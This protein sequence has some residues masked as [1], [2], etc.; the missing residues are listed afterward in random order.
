VDKLAFFNSQTCTSN[1][2]FITKTTHGYENVGVGLQKDSTLMGTFPIP[3]PDVPPPLVASI[4]MI[5]T[6]VHETHSSSDPWII[7]KPSD[8]SR[9]GDQMPLSQVESSYHAIQS[10]DPTTPLGDSSPNPFHVIFPTDKMIISVLSMED[11]PWND[12]H[13][14]SILFLEPHTLESYQWI[15]TPS[16]VVFIASVPDSPHDVLYEGNLSN[17]SPTIPLDIS[18]KPGVVENVHIVAS[19]S[20]DEVVTY[21][22]LFQEFCDVFAWRYEEMHSIDPDIVVHEIKTYMGAKPILQR[23]HPVHPCKAST[24]KIEVEKL[25]KAGFIYPVALTDWVYNLVLVNKKQGTICVYVDYRD[26]NR[27]CPKDNFP[28]PFIDQIMDDCAGSEIFS[29]I[30][31]F[32]RYNQINILLTD[33]HKTTF[34]CPWGTFSYRKLPF[35]LKNVGATFQWAMSYYFHDIKCCNPIIYRI[36]W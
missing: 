14:H 4:N 21:T 10:N 34:I 3:P 35:G 33:Q 9:Y 30:E 23:L 29:L 31:G 8:Y 5:S 17:I 28:T 22:Y 32:S 11:T 26:V 20:T 18:I 6:S 7:L 25:L 15:S 24:T 19:C 27:A 12:G 2:P 36:N 13:D 16:T 1:I